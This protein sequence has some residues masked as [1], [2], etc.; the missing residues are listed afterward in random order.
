[1]LRCYTATFSSNTCFFFLRYACTALHFPSLRCYLATL[2]RMH[3]TLPFLQY[4]WKVLCFHVFQLF[5][6]FVFKS[7]LYVLIC[8]YF[9]FIFF[10]PDTV[11]SICPWPPL[12]F[13]CSTS[14]LACGDQNRSWTITYVWDAASVSFNVKSFFVPSSIKM[15]QYMKKWKGSMLRNTGLQR[16][17]YQGIKMNDYG[18]FGDVHILTTTSLKECTEP[19][20]EIICWKVL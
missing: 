1:M 17:E 13:S 2:L 10:S 16:N 15:H 14:A 12:H 4:Y 8:N 11:L 20:Q 19:Q 7:F 6:F 5:P 3:L 9:Y 18:A